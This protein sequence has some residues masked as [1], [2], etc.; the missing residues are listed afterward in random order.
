MAI[1]PVLGESIAVDVE[2]KPRR[3]GGLAGHRFFANTYD[4]KTNYED[5]E[6]TVYRKQQ[7]AS[8][9]PLSR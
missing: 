5:L 8:H 7:S 9:E 3:W 6:H 4:C 2:A 1:P